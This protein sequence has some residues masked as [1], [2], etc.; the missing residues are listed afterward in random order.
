MVVQRMCFRLYIN[1][2]TWQGS[3]GVVVER[4]CF[5]FYLARLKRCGCAGDG[6]EGR[7][8]DVSSGLANWHIYYITILAIDHA[9]SS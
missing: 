1:K 2:F 6:G 8:A 7:V 9:T 5:R 4:V 3:H